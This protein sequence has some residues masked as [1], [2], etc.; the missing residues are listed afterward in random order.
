MPICVRYK[1]HDFGMSVKI[2]D[3]GIL[4]TIF[5]LSSCEVC[6]V[7]IFNY[8]QFQISIPSHSHS[9]N[10][11]INSCSMKQLSHT[12]IFLCHFRDQKRNPSFNSHNPPTLASCLQIKMR[13]WSRRKQ[14]QQR[15][16]A[17]WFY[18]EDI[19]WR[20]DS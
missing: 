11:L 10:F 5:V 14:V 12:N 8:L 13:G 9:F 7:W 18:E 6:G 15:F 19:C 3:N 1:I 2:F 16:W 17:K 4:L 20:S